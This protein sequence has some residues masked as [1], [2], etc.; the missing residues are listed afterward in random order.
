LGG[1]EPTLDLIDALR[2]TLPT[3]SVNQEL[4]L[5]HEKFVPRIQIEDI[6]FKYPNSGKPALSGIN[7]E[8]KGGSVVA[9]VGPSGG[10]KTTLVDVILGII[11]PNSGKVLIS[12]LSP[13][14]AIQI[15]PGAISYVPQDVSIIDGT[16]RENIAMGF[17]IEVATDELV[18][19]AI[20]LAGLKDFVADLPSGLDT[21]VGEKGARISGGQR[22]RL[23]IARA[24]FTN[25]KLLVL[26][27]ATSALDGETES[28]ITDSIL[29][30]KG[31]VTVVM[32]AHRLSTVRNADQVV[33]MSEGFVKAVGTFESVRSSVPDFD[34]QAQLMGL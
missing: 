4:D 21:Y 23:G 33:Y 30:L 25:P 29:S 9:L 5:I 14:E 15:S 17:P 26:D 24:L 12:N 3:A 34:N 8:I 2:G 7:I 16:I 1:S 22:Q 32:V 28:K 31:K 13:I 6:S 27:E 18:Q 20:D 11:E 19:N 10:G